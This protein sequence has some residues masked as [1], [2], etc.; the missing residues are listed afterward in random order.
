M[1][2]PLSRRSRR[3]IQFSFVWLNIF[4]MAF[5]WP[6]QS[7]MANPTGGTVVAGSAAISSAGN[8]LTVTQNSA[9]AI[10]NWQSFSINQREMTQS[11]SLLDQLQDIIIR[12]NKP[13]KKVYSL[14]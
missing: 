9:R 1:A 13:S 6:I 8:T 5:A 11:F 4:T 14:E 7:A 12:L 2:K 10:V 3:R